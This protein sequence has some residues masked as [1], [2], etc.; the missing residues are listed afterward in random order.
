VAAVLD[1]LYVARQRLTAEL[2]DITGISDIVRGASDPRET[3]KAQQIKGQFANKRLSI[4]QDEML[5]MARDALSIQAEIVCKHYSPDIIKVVSS[6][7]QVVRNPVTKQFDEIRFMQCIML[8]KDSML[9][10]F[11]V[12]IDEKSLAMPDIA[13]EQQQRIQ[14]VQSIS[15]YLTA[16]TTMITAAPAAGPLLGDILLW[17]VRGFPMARTE[18][19]AIE[20]S[21]KNMLGTPLPQEQEKPAQTGKSPEELQVENKKVD[22]KYEIDKGRLQLDARREH[23]KQ[24]VGVDTFTQARE[25]PAARR[26]PA[27]DGRGH[28]DLAVGARDDPTRHGERWPKDPLRHGRSRKIDGPLLLF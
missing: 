9:R 4:R 6:A 16:A 5:R 18:E 27:S 3:A 22:Q 10:S 14:F 2:Y 12:K 25:R 7:E 21:L 1:K 20:A 13:D 24:V 8:L 28:D 17:A 15:S 11:R 23:P 26:D 19:A